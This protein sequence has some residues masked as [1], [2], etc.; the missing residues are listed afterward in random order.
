M[1]YTLPH[2]WVN[3]TSYVVYYTTCVV[4]YTANV[5]S[6]EIPILLKEHSPP[7][8][9]ERLIF[10]KEI[11][12]STKKMAIFNFDQFWTNVMVSFFIFKKSNIFLKV[13]FITLCMYMCMYTVA[14]L[15]RRPEGAV[16]PLWERKTI[17][18]AFRRCQNHWNY[19]KMTL[20]N[21]IRGCKNCWAP[22]DKQLKIRY[23]LCVILTMWWDIVL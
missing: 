8:V 21:Y 15:R 6:P 23:C 7:L 17:N 10:K 20:N 14:D 4:Y 11:V 1:W 19:L 22:S 5:N 13:R 12:L 2:L 9:F 16:A 3:V 18:K